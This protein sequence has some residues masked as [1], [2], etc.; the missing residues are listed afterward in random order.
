M[1][2][3]LLI[4]GT[5]PEIIKL[6]PVYTELLKSGS[7]LID[8]FLSGQHRDLAEGMMSI[9]DMHADYAGT[10]LCGT[11]TL[12]GKLGILLH[13][14][15]SILQARH[16]DWIIVQG[17]TITALAGAIVGFLEHRPVAHVEAG[18]RTFN[19]QAPWPEEF[20]RRAITLGTKVHF[21]P[22]EDAKANLLEEGVQPTAIHVT[23]NTGLDALRYV[24]AKIRFDYT[25]KEKKIDTIPR[26]K[27]LILVTGH[28]RENAGGP[29]ENITRAI[30]T[31]A[32]DA[33]KFLVWPVHPNP[34]VRKVVHA[35]LANAA[36]VL[37]LDPVG[38]PDFV[39]LMER[40]WTAITDSGGIQEEFPSF[41]RPLVVTRTCTERPEAVAAGFA[42]LAGNDPDRIV[43]AVRQFTSQS[44]PRFIEGANPFGVGDAA[45]KICKTLLGTSEFTREARTA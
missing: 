4:L 45:I 42:H 37:L 24:R 27:K 28:R 14:L 33:D 39:Y 10:D 30:A 35:R 18:L 6:G 44:S 8:V 25:P 20:D 13:E 9:F 15:S 1:K 43:S 5:R 22:T 19:L 32:S 3:I 21:A 2:R 23:G 34:V 36:N 16:Y 17:D 31:L 11:T 12:S 26:D 41:N 40:A 38:Y 29:L 7:C